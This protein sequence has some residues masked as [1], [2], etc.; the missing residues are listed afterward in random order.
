MRRF[1]TEAA[2]VADVRY[3]NGCF[4][5]PASPQDEKFA[6][7]GDYLLFVTNFD[8]LPDEELLFEYGALNVEGGAAARQP[9][10]VR[11]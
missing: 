10:A 4:E 9:L 5:A 8:T 1:A 3:D 2:G 11:L 6:A 7:I